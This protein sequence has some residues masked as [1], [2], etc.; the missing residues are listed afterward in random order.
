MAARSAPGKLDVLAAKFENGMSRNYRLGS[1]L[2]PMI[3]KYQV[4]I[5]YVVDS[6]LVRELLM[7]ND[8]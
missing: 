6:R 4:S 3:S 5:P 1:L 2:G 8:G 7:L